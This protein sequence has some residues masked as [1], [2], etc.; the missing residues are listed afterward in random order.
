MRFALVLCV[1]ALTAAPACDAPWAGPSLPS[2][3]DWVNYTE[4]ERG[5]VG[6]GVEPAIIAATSLDE[7]RQMLTATCQRASAC[8]N[9]PGGCWQGLQEQPGNVYLAV[10]LT[11]LCAQPSKEDIAASSTAIYFVEWVGH[12]HGVCDAMLA[13]PPFRLFIVPRAGLRAGPV[14]VELRVQNEGQGTT[15]V[16][17]QVALS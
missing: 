15:T 17:T 9:P 13:L 12:S 5:P 10:L 7:L 3:A 6:C 16:D 14:T 4:S 1:L 8:T 2:G 11:P